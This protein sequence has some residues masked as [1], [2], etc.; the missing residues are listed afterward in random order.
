MKRTALVNIDFINDIVHEKG[1]FGDHYSAIVK[2][3]KVIQ[4]ANEVINFAR[5]NN[6][7]N[8]YVKVGF[9]SDYKEISSNNAFFGKAVELNAF[10]LDTW[11]TEFH[12]DLDYKDGEFIIIKNRISAL[13]A[14]RLECLLRAQNIDNLIITGVATD[15]AV[16]LLAR[17][18]VDRDFKVIICKDACATFSEEVQEATLKS[19]ELMTIVVSNN[20]LS[21]DLLN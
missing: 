18:A 11:G 5:K 1:A 10:K 8:V 14:T 12:P 19:L 9:S 16:Q 2:E 7:L 6:I 20:E 4:R 17:D 21:T 15:L 3:R 13:Y